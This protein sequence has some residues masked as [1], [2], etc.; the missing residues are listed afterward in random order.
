MKSYGQDI[1]MRSYMDMKS[2]GQDIDMKSYRQ[3]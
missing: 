2:H 1:D 3:D